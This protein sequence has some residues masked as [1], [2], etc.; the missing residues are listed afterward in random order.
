M[1]DGAAGLVHGQRALELG[2][3]EDDNVL[4]T[5][6]ASAHLQLNDFVSAEAGYRR[7]VEIWR[8]HGNPYNIAVALA[9]LGDS[10]RGLGRRDEALAA[11]DEA[12]Q[13]N[14]QIGNLKSVT[15]CLLITGRTHLHFDELDQAATVLQSAVDLAREQ[16]LPAYV[17]EGTEGLDELRR[18][19]AEPA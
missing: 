14:E 8:Q 18:R 16:R 17:Q 7:A 12:L 10:L 19:R 3:P 5:V 2:V 15:S 13:I 6:M 4:V 9:N 11:L 1:G